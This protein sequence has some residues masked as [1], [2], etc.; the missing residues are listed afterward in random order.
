M[1]GFDFYNFWTVGNLVLHGQNPYS[2]PISFYPPLTAYAFSIFALL[3]FEVAFGLWMGINLIV[4]GLALRKLNLGRSARYWYGFAPITFVLVTGQNDIIFFWLASF[5]VSS[6]E[7]DAWKGWR[8]VLMAALITLKPQVAFIVLPWFLIRWLLKEHR[9]LIRWLAVCLTMHLIPVIFDP[10]IYLKW[11][12]LASGES[13]WRLPASPGVFALSTFNLPAWFLIPVA[14][15][16]ALYGLFKDAP[17]SRLTQIL[18]MPWGLW[19]ENIF[20]AGQAP[21]WLLVPLSWVLFYI[22]YRLHTNLPFVVIPTLV[23]LWKTVLVFFPPIR[24]NTG[25]TGG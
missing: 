8:T 4:L 22:S 5:L 3:P 2:Y 17:F 16:L 19:Y 7:E 25:H 9:K 18:A 23:F 12:Q 15:A 21:W 1:V 11:F 10:G 13:G 6:G 14:I 20:I 24:Y